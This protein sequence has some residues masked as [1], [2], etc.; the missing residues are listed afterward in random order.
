M[1]SG[2]MFNGGGASY[3]NPGKTNLPQGTYTTDAAFTAQIGFDAADRAIG[4]LN[5]IFAYSLS[6]RQ[7]DMLENIAQLK[8]NADKE[9]AGFEKELSLEFL[10]N[11]KE[12][13]ERMNGAGGL[14]ERLAQMKFNNDLEIHKMD[15]EYQKEVRAMENF[16]P[17][18]FGMRSEPY[19]GRPASLS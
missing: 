15:L 12:S 14:N 9:I 13:D 7:F 2:G 10:K 18:A 17:E 4:L 16:L 3:F 19:Y 1:K 11:A 5:N 8:I 6:I